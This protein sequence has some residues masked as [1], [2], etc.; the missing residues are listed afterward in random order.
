MALCFFCPC[1]FI[2]PPRWNRG[3]PN[4]YCGFMTLWFYGHQGGKS[5]AYFST[6]LPS[7]R[8]MALFLRVLP[9]YSALVIRSHTVSSSNWKKEL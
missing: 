9:S 3:A 5:L 4:C 1:D 8:M 7:R 2:G 6:I